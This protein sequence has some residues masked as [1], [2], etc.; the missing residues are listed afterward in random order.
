MQALPGI[1]DVRP[2]WAAASGVPHRREPRPG[3][4][5][6]ARHRPDR[7]DVRRCWP[8]DGDH[9]GGPHRRGARRGGAGRPSDVH[10]PVTS[11]PLPD[12]H[13]AARESGAAPGR[14]RWVRS[15]GSRGRRRPRRS[16][17]RTCSA[18]HRVAGTTPDYSIAEASARRIRER[19]G[20]MAGLPEATRCQLGGETEQL[21]ETGGYVLE[22]LLLAV[23]LIFLILASQFES[24]DAAVRDHALAAALADRRAAGAADHRRHAQHDVDDRGDHADGAGDQ[25]RHP[26]GR[27]RQRAARDGATGTPRWWR[28][29]ACGCAP[30]S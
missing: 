15:R 8:A 28:P 17:G 26:A 19:A 21:A 24:P 1:V 23:I 5:A 25:E 16:T 9:V 18:W 22:S 4:R 12:R 7:D 29:G 3:Q 13:A 20:S 10:Q 6:G 11:S 14:C 2:R 30:S 27:Q